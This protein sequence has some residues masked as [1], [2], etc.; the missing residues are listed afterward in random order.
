MCKDQDKRPLVEEMI[1]WAKAHK[2]RLVWCCVDQS[3]E[4][5]LADIGWSTLSCIQEDVLREL[6]PCQAPRR[7]SIRIR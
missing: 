5:I 7:P 6:N 3:F 4:S 2:K 1:K